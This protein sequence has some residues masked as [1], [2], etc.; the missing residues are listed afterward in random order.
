MVFDL[1]GCMEVTKI[2]F[3][4]AKKAYLELYG[5]SPIY[6][7]EFSSF[8]EA[9]LEAWKSFDYISNAQDEYQ[10]A[11]GMCDCWQLTEN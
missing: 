6:N 3:Q 8:D 11:Q 9:F 5:N 1:G 7:E 4:Q 10:F 2:S